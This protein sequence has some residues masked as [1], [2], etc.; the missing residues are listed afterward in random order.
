L[1]AQVLVN[2]KN[3]VAINPHLWNYQKAIAA[4]I[5]A[6][7]KSKNAYVYQSIVPSQLTPLENLQVAEFVNNLRPSKDE[8]YIFFTP[9]TI[10]TDT[11]VFDD[12]AFR[13]DM[14]ELQKDLVEAKKN[15][16]KVN[17]HIRIDTTLKRFER[18]SSWAE[19]FSVQ[20]D[21]DKFKVS[22]P[23][24]I[25]PGIDIPLPPI[26]SINALVN[27]AIKRA[28]IYVHKIPGEKSREHKIKVEVRS[29]DSTKIN[30][31][32]FNRIFIDS[33]MNDQFRSLD[34]LKRLDFDSFHF[35]NDSSSSGFNFFLNDS[36][37]LNQNEELRRQMNELKEEMRKFREEIRNFQMD[38]PSNSDT[39]K[40][41]LKGI[42]I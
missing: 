3:A 21:A 29:G 36:I 1:L 11:F 28:E 39:V 9:D 42:E 16:A 8:K 12:R 38:P 13:K 18:D 14:S 33:L 17:Y 20:I 6:Y 19:E 15:I 30:N 5:L 37:M 7:A 4:E 32:N 23:K 10:F 22:I 34:S 2:D 24:F 40:P 35:F 27:D 41:K 25:M 31:F 26:D